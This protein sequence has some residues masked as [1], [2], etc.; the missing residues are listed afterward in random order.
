MHLQVPLDVPVAEW[1]AMTDDQRTAYLH[2]LERAAELTRPLP[3]GLDAIDLY[4]DREAGTWRATVRLYLSAESN[5]EVAGLY[6]N[7]WF[8]RVGIERANLE[9]DEHLEINRHLHEGRYVLSLRL[10][11]KGYTSPT[12]ALEMLLATIRRLEVS[13][14]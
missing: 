11:R 14:A 10:T 9:P 8:G 1:N 5:A 13:P 4:R 7:S 6:A 2:N 12:D 3:P